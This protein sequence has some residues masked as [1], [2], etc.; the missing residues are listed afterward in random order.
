MKL[1]SLSRLISLILVSNSTIV[2]G[3]VVSKISNK[4]SL[5]ASGIRHVVLINKIVP[6]TILSPLRI[7][8]FNGTGRIKCII[9]SDIHGRVLKRANPLKGKYSYNFRHKLSPG[10]YYVSVTTESH[11]FTSKYLVTR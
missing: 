10:C 2:S 11:V 8:V 1:L 7:S 4:F 6:E 5:G 3:A 9:V